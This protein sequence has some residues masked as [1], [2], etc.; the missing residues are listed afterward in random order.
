VAVARADPGD[1]LIDRCL[2]LDKVRQKSKAACQHNTDLSAEI[3]PLSLNFIGFAQEIADLETQYQ[4]LYPWHHLM[5]HLRFAGTTRAAK[6]T[7]NRCAL[8]K[9]VVKMQVMS[10]CLYPNHN[11]LIL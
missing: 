4:N 6:S 5:V 8:A 10:E 1:T 9:L 7:R 2:K 3:P 11:D